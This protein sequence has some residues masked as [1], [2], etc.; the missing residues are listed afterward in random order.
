M[1]GHSKD[2]NQPERTVAFIVARLGSSRLPAKQ[3]R[4]IGHKTLIDHLLDELKKCRHIDEIVLA[5]S[6]EPENIPLLSWT[7]KHGISAYSYQGDVNRVTTRLRKGAEKFSADICVLVSGDCPLIHA[8]AIDRLI[9]AIKCHPEADFV[10]AGQNKPGNYPALQGVLVARIKAWQRADDLSDRP[11]LKEHHF[12][13]LHQR[14]D[15]FTCHRITLPEEIHAPFH[16]RYSIDTWAD[17]EFHNALYNALAARGS[18]YSLSAAIGLLQQDHSL[19]DINSHVHQKGVEESSRKVLV[20]VD[21][22]EDYGYGHLMRSRELALQITERL[23]W[24][25]TF[26]SGDQEARSS[27]QAVG[28]P[29]LPMDITISDLF[30][31]EKNVRLPSFD[32]IILDLNSDNTLPCRWREALSNETKVVVLDRIDDWTQ[33]SDLVIIPGVTA[34]ILTNKTTGENPAILA[35]RD[36]VIL[37]RE[38]S[39][40][41]RNKVA[42]D[43]DLLVY[44]HHKWQQDVIRKFA[45]KTDL[46]V[47]VIEQQCTNFHHLLARSRVLLSGFG[48]SFYEA[49]ALG[50]YPVTWPFSAAHDRDAR[51]FYRNLG[52][53]PI[54]VPDDLR[55]DELARIINMAL[56]EQTGDTMK[57]GTPNIVRKIKSLFEQ[58]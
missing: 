46:S 19:L 48:V 56:G 27:L 41:T 31:P 58:P 37:R 30:D 39:R 33:E 45:G 12:P 23:G 44:L 38:I 20:V 42:K 5:T 32:L 15:L 8:P 2:T 53:K 9:S 18:A 47:H 28:F 24:P 6:D 10:T 17:L 21:A 57:D 7:R 55:E 1:Q 25:C 54:M 16:H 11:A 40:M 29:L 36:Y 14:P 43:I 3:F 35:G 49:V 26:L 50:T 4:K 13:I 51:S 22:G 52:L 34:Q